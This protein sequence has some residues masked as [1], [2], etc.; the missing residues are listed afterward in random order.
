VNAYEMKQ[1]ARKQRLLERAERIRGLSEASYRRARRIMDMIPFGQPILVGHHSER[2]ARRDQDRIHN[3]IG[4]SIELGKYADDL[5]RRAEA[6][7]TAGISSDD[8]DAIGKLREKLSKL[9]ALQAKMKA[10]NKAIRAKD[11][12]A[13]RALGFDESQIAKLKTPDFCGRIGFPDYALTNNNGN[14][15]RIRERIAQLESASTAGDKEVEGAGYTLR[16]DTTENR[17]M[18]LFPG[19]PPA[20]VRDLLK[21]WGFRWSPTRSAWVRFLNDS[22]RVAAQCVAEKLNTETRT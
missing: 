9:E 6:V 15:R 8:P 19:K 21:S 22:G 11:D 4:K 14:M 5:E 20:D 12:D 18:F 13:L 16:E 10:G 2:H 17:V 3:G 7:G 1:G